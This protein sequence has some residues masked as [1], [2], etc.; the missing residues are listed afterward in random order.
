MTPG[1]AATRH[2]EKGFTL[3]E[4]L[5]VVTIIGIVAAIAIPGLSRARGAAAE[6]ST[7]GSLR[8]IHGAQVLFS[9]SCGGGYYAPTIALLA[10]KPTGSTTAFIGP[11]F[12]ADVIDRQEYRIRFTLGTVVAT[13]P[14][15]C[16]GIAKGQ[17]V[18]TFFVG[19][20]LLQTNSERVSR[21]FGLNASGV[22]FQSTKRVPVTLTGDPPPPAKPL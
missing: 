3:I 5:M 20:D 4:L 8:V 11:E 1:R 16:N 9:V 19:A 2:F 7:I 22:I 17:T 6:S 15:T 18:N 14:A 10:T 13:A 12:A 21:Y